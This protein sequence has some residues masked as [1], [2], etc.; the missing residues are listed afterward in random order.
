MPAQPLALSD[1]LCHAI[2]HQV[3]RTTA[4]LLLDDAAAQEPFRTNFYIASRGVRSVLCTPLFHRKHLLG[5]LYLENNLT[6]GA[7]N[8]SR[9]EILTMLSTQAAISI[10]NAALYRRLEEHSRTLEHHVAERTEAL[11]QKNAELKQTLETVEAMQAEI[12][13]QKKMAALGTLTSGIAH[14]LKNPLN[15]M[16]NFA[17]LSLELLLEMGEEISGA[18]VP[19]PPLRER[20]EALLKEL[21]LTTTK[22]VEH[23]HRATRIIDGMLRHAPSSLGQRRPTRLN[24]LVEETVRFIQH[25]LHTKVPR[26]Q[27][28]IE[29]SLDAAVPPMLLVAEDISR[30]ILNLLENGCYAAQKKAHRVGWATQPR[31]WVSTRWMG[32]A[33]EV[34]VRDNGDGV[35]LA[36][37][38]KIF[39]PF[40][41][42]KPPGEGTGLGLSISHEIV[43]GANGGKLRIESEEGQYAEFIVELPVP[44]EPREEESESLG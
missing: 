7:F 14:E 1:V 10:E 30:V 38:H 15:F 42:T 9:L 44:A 8:A 4:P 27:V 28:D 34:R 25:A 26:I 18:W 19:P 39:M 17:E 11:H 12:L 32:S 6:P 5:L 23:G 41:T 33:V 24:Q 13:L 35:P 43:V 22:V 29:I 16:N 3:L 20:M 31:V 2:A 40:F 37:R 36:E 21:V